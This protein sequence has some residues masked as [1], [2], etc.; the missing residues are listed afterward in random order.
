MFFLSVCCQCHFP[1]WES[2]STML[3]N[4]MLVSGPAVGEAQTNLILLLCVLASNIHSCQ[5]QCVFFCENSQ[6]PFI[7]SIDTDSA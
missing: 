4:T 5:N 3:F 7:Y 6:C 1:H 2:Q